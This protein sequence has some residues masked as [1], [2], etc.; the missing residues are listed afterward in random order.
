MKEKFEQVTSIINQL[1]ILIERELDVLDINSIQEIQLVVMEINKFLYH[2]EKLSFQKEYNLDNIKH[3]KCYIYEVNE[4]ISVWEDSISK[5]DLAPNNIDEDFFDIYEYFKYIE[6]EVIYNI[7]VTKFL[8]L[9]E[10]LKN[11]FL[12]LPKRY[13]FLKNKIDYLNNDYSLIAEHISLM[14]TSIDEYKWIYDH[15]EDYRSKKVLNGII[16]YWFN[17]DIVSMH[18]LCETL[19]S[20]YFD[21]DIL[22]CTKNEVL[23]DMGAY[24]GDSAFDFVNTFGDYAKIYAYE[25]TPRTFEVL[26]KNLE[27]LKNIYPI[28]KGLGLEESVMYITDTGNGAGNTVSYKGTIAVPIV[29]LDEDIQEPVSLIKMDIE[30]A[31]KDALLGSIRH[32]KEEKPKL[33]ISAYHI[34]NDLFQIP[35]LVNEIRD[36]YKFYLRFNGHNCLWPCDY[37]LFAV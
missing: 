19:Y 29:S 13:S 11:E 7:T 23:V 35:K 20:D 1:K 9:P 10:E 21:L 32:I 36:D 4:I 14:C 17:F 16:K 15:L 5:R 18:K 37:V 12:T 26:K 6:E 28:Q 8:E 27:Q 34:P 30:G 31:E 24:I 25:V 2:Y 3:R 33:L 22:E